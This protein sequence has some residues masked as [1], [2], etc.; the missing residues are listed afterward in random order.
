MREYKIVAVRRGDDRNATHYKLDDGSVVS[1]EDAI[2]MCNQGAFPGYHKGYSHLG[3]PFLADNR[4]G[5]ERDNI[6]N[7]P[8]F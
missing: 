3:T 4:D 1:I 2:E 7:L 5:E 6:R 8:S